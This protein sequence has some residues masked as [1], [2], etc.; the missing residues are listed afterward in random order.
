MSLPCLQNDYSDYVDDSTSIRTLPPGQQLRFLSGEP[1][2]TRT[3][4][5]TT[6][7]AHQKQGQEEPA[8][9]ADDDTQGFGQTSNTNSGTTAGRGRDVRLRGRLAAYP[10]TYPYYMSAT[11]QAR[12]E[13]MHRC[14]QH[15]NAFTRHAAHMMDREP[16]VTSRPRWNHCVTCRQ[17]KLAAEMQGMGLPVMV[18]WGTNVKVRQAKQ[19]TK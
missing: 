3:S 9:A 16:W 11:A 7:K 12:R 2:N 5:R 17:G 1:A 8:Q 10:P 15:H 18:D 19:V 4:T 13:V 6:W 14:G